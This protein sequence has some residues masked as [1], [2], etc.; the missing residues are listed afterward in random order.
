[1]LIK[2]N[3]Y[4]TSLE[5][6]AM[7]FGIVSLSMKYFAEQ[8]VRHVNSGGTFDNA[9]FVALRAECMRYLKD[10]AAQGATLEQEVAALNEAL[11]M[12]QQMMDD[13]MAAAMAPR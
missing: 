11:I 4:I 5:T 13:V 8:I 7:M 6:N 1:M 9:R 10:I 12:F 2:V 3:E